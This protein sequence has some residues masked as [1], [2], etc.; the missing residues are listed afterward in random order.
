MKRAD[1]T[2]SKR[3]R[4]YK[5]QL[6]ENFTDILISWELKFEKG[7]RSLETIRNILYMYSVSNSLLINRWQWNIMTQLTPKIRILTI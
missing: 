4:Q 1:S 7:D 6:P 5:L 3:N 2:L